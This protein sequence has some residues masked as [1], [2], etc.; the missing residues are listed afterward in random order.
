MIR[1]RHARGTR[2]ILFIGSK[3][4]LAGITRQRMPAGSVKKLIMISEY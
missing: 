1:P 3:P 4:D 2:A